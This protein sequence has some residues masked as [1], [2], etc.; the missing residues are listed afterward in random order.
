MK[1]P[2]IGLSG[3]RRGIR[4]RLR[5]KVTI[6]FLRK[7]IS[8][9]VVLS[10]IAVI[11]IGSIG[12]IAVTN[13]SVFCSSCHEMKVQCTT[14][15]MSSHKGVECEQCHLMPGMTNMVKSKISALRLAIASRAAW[16][17]EIR[18]TCRMSTARN[19]T[20]RPGISWFTTG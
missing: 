8:L 3:F 5:S 11:G 14:W 7:T 2:H 15:R 19:A 10:I 16:G 12:G 18:A 20:P 13:R 6:P 1:F 9:W 17:H 4:E